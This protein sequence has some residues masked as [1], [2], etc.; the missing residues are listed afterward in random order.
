M[1]RGAVTDGTVFDD[2]D[3]WAEPFQVGTRTP[4][5]KVATEMAVGYSDICALGED[6][7][8]IWKQTSP[9]TA[10]KDVYVLQETTS[11]DPGH[12]MGAPRSA[13][14]DIN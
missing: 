3:V 11:A 12:T 14:I 10:R 5:V 9:A 8:V 7:M 2:P 4:F 6:F 1:S 13:H